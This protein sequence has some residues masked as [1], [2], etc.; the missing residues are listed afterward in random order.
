MSAFRKLWGPPGW[1]LA[2]ALALACAILPKAAWACASCSSGTGDPLVLYPN[3]RFKIYVGANYSLDRAML[4]P[5]GTVGGGWGAQSQQSLILSAG[6]AINL[7]SFLTVTL[8][9]VRN[10]ANDASAM[11]LGDPSLGMRYTLL[12]QHF[13]NPWVPQ[14]QGVAGLRVGLGRAKVPG[15]VLRMDEL[16]RFG[17]GSTEARLGFDVWWGMAPLKVGA[18]SFLLYPFAMEQVSGEVTRSGATWRALVS[19][20]H[21]VGD[22]GRFLATLVRDD[23]ADLVVLGKGA[24]PNS[25]KTVY[26]LSVSLDAEITPT[27]TVRIAAGRTAL[28]ASSN[29]TQ[30]INISLA[31]MKAW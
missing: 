6:A 5:D 28:F 27:D 21:D 23:Q 7:R 8:P 30:D 9:Y 2:L 14:V 1:A 22:W 13:D 20:G 29:T 24:I 19:L 26:S 18:A 17:Q 3:E 15:V 11:G 4:H 10:V 12:Q 25:G 31:Y 16:D